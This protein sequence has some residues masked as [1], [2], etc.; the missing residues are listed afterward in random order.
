MGAALLIIV[1]FGIYV[2]LALLPRGRAAAYGLI[3]ALAILGLSSRFATFAPLILP[4]AAGVA[5]AALALGARHVLG[6]KLPDKTY[7]AFLGLPPMLVVI[8]LMLMA[9]G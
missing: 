7:F 1:F 6:H 8:A 9:R 4:A 5:A 3:V 2:S